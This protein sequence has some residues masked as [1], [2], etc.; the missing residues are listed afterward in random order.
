[1]LGGSKPGVE[2]YAEIEDGTYGQMCG[3]RLYREDVM[4]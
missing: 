2:V 4:A 3:F 1:V